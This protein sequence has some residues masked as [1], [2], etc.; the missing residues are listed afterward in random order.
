LYAGRHPDIVSKI[1]A[2]LKT[3]RLESPDWA[4]KDLPLAGQSK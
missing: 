3:A 4:P 1:D 2:D